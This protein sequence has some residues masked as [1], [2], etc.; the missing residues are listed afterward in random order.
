MNTKIILIMGLPGSGKTTLAKHLLDYIDAEHY[1]ADVIRQIENDWDFSEEGRM[2]QVY[3][4]RELAQ[5]TKRPYAIC[6]FVCPLVEGREI[7]Q[8][9]IVIWMNTI[10]KGRFED[11][12]QVF[13]EPEKVDYLVTDYNAELH[14][15]VISRTILETSAISFDPK[16]PTTQ[17]L[18][19]YQP[20]HDGHLALFERCHEQTGQVVIMV[21]DMPADIKNPFDF[22]TIKQNIKL[23]L[24]GEGYEENHD[25][26]IIKVPNIV[27]ISY[28]RDVGYSIT[29]HKFDKDVEE[30]SA[31]E[32][33]RQI[34]IKEN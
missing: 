11:T 19:R 31:T 9:D 17:M 8:P 13:V 1:E 16:L 10:E 32:I 24:L 34:G 27:D 28:G 20:F 30:I 4:M 15:E 5:T 33:R 25:Y 22:K 12:N 6:D 26:V 29:E 2:R 3:R 18:G 7:L 21:R 23:Y 14:S